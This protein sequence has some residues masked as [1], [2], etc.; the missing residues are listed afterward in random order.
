MV[1]PLPPNS[2][3]DVQLTD[4][5]E[6]DFSFITTTVD[7]GGLVPFMPERNLSV[8]SIAL[9]FPSWFFLHVLLTL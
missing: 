7:T 8:R 2:A 5:A 3:R 1:Q 4:F 9:F 6:E